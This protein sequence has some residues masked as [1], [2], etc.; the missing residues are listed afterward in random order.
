MGEKE[1]RQGEGHVELHCSLYAG[2]AVITQGAV[3]AD[4]P[5]EPKLRQRGLVFINRALNTAPQRG[6][7]IK[8]LTIASK[9]LSSE[10]PT[11]N[12]SGN[13]GIECFSR[14]GGLGILMKDHGIHD[15]SYSHIL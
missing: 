1:G 15:M 3:E 5:S 11:A 8:L 6:S 9:E 13:K 7:S 10:L 12:S 2:F 14:E 4:D